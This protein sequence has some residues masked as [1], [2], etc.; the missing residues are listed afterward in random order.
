MNADSASPHDLGGQIAVVTGAAQGLGLGIAAQLARDGAAVV[1]ADLQEE[2]A[3]A[4]ATGLQEQGLA[5]QAGHLDVADSDQ[6]KVFFDQ[7]ISQ[8]GRLDIL[9][10]NAGVGQV[11]TPL[12]ELGD[13][14]WERVLRV[15]LTG[16]FYCCRAAGR[17]MER[18]ESGAIVNIASINGQNPAALVVA[19]NVAKAGVISLTRTLALEMAAYGVRVNAV[20]PGPVYTEFNR[21]VMAQ[22]SQSLGLNEEQMIE[23]IRSAIPLGRWGEPIDIARAVAFLCSPAASWI[24][25]EIMRVS[26][27]LEGVS[28]APPKRPKG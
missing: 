22:R 16:A 5:V 23:R 2:K 4:A 12:V 6:V 26:G 14:E 13:R 19:Y 9:V 17:I 20:C 8:R 3:W 15:T 27:G 24:T 18:Q 1:I 28:A 25:G 11:V 7:V 21:T 10:N